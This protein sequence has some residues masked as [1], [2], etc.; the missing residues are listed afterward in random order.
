MSLGT[1]IADHSSLEPLVAVR[2][3]FS[4]LSVGKLRRLCDRYFLLL[5]SH[6]PPECLLADYQAACEELQQRQWVSSAV[7]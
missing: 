3:D 4:D 5:D 2:A 6:A 7:E 1:Q